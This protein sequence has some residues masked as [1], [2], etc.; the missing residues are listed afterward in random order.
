MG[1]IL[2]IKYLSLLALF[3][4]C[5]MSTYY[6]LAG[7][8]LADVATV[9]TATLCAAMPL[10]LYMSAPVALARAA[11]TARDLGVKLK[12]KQALR[13]LAET[14]TIV[15]NKTGI[16]TAGEPYVAGLFPEGVSQSVLLAQAASAERDSV[17]PIGQ[18]IYSSA[19]E[20]GLRLAPLMTFSE[21]AGRGVEALVNRAPVRVGTAE[22]L[23]SEGIKISAELLTKA[24]QI[25]LHGQ[26]AIFVANGRSCRGIIA[27]ADEVP[28]G[29]Q[30]ALRRLQRLGMQL[31]LLTRD[32]KRTANAIRKASGID[33]ARYELDMG[34]RHREVQLLQARGE[35]VALLTSNPADDLLIGTATPKILL[36]GKDKGPSASDA[37]ADSTPLATPDIVISG[38]LVT[39]A[40]LRELAEA[41]AAII[42]QNRR[43]TLLGY[44]LLVPPAL[45]LLHTFGGPFLPP[46]AALAGQLLLTLVITLNSLRA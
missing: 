13:E 32:S 21:T 26:T 14:T 36:E 41:T 42:R 7:E 19:L 22:Y 5:G 38:E 10:A 44:I 9:F 16:I 35:S 24:D 25:E 31:I 46:L 2:H 39:L 17:S 37:P 29:T 20:R 43:L 3:L 27:L 30:K 6:F 4:A 11:R 45:G 18:A 34:A 12:N 1:K 8:T 33:D 40:S 23:E 15:M 28:A